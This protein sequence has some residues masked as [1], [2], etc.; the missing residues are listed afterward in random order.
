MSDSN[1]RERRA[2]GGCAARG[3]RRSA[4]KPVVS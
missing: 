4:K 1:P 2:L 3:F